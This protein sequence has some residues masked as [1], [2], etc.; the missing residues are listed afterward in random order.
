M[1][2]KL[3]H[4]IQLEGVD[5]VGKS[6][7]SNRLKEI[8]RA[9]KKYDVFTLHFPFYDSPTGKIIK[10]FLNGKLVGNP[11]DVDPITSSL[12]YTA[13]R[14]TC[15][16]NNPQ[17]FTDYDVLIFD[18]SYM[19]NFFFQTAKYMHN[20]YQSHYIENVISFIKTFYPLEIGNS[21]L[22]NFLP[23]IKTF[24]LRHPSIDVNFELMKLRGGAEDLHESN[25]EYLKNVDDN[26]V[27]IMDFLSDSHFL[28]SLSDEE[29][30][31]YSSIEILCSTLEDDSKGFTLR[32]IDDI[33]DDIIF[34]TN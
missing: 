8:Y 25:R 7:I 5:A 34:H 13:D 15:F 19:S 24:L 26:S 32:K 12:Y 1:K 23:L 10:E 3:K 33:C 2:S 27:N 4:I 21:P 29:H 16:R 20:E 6:L 9:E 22:K 30:A 18:R 28:P 17:I 31:I 11:V 14:L